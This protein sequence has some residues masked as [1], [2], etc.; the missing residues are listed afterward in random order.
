MPDGGNRIQ[1]VEIKGPEPILLVSAYMP[2]NGMQG[3]VDE[4]EDTLD[5]LSEITAKY[6]SHQIIIGGDFNEDIIEPNK[7]SKRLQLLQNFLSENKLSYR[8]VGKTYVNPNGIETSAIDYIFYDDKINDRLLSAI[9]LEAIPTNVSDH[10]PVC[11]TF[12]YR[13]RQFSKSTDQFKPS[14]KVKW[15]KLDKDRYQSVVTSKLVSLEHNVSSAAVLDVQ[16]QKIN[17]ILVQATDE[18]R[19]KPVKRHRKAR[20]NVWTAEIGLAVS[21]KKKA[22]WEWKQNNRPD[23]SDNVFVVNKKT[24]TKR[25]RKLC[26][27][28]SAKARGA[29]RQQI[30]DAKSN[31]TKLF[32]KLIDKQRGRSNICVNELN[33]GD[34]T[35]STSSEVL[36]GWREH[37]SKLATPNDTLRKDHAY[38]Q[39]VKTEMLEIFDICTHMANSPTNIETITVPEVKEAISSLNKNKAA[40]IYGIVAEHILYGGK[41]LLEFLTRII[42]QLFTFGKIPESLKLGVLTPVYKRKGLNTEAKNYRGITILPVI[43]KILEAVL[44]KKIQPIINANQS[45]LQR[46]FTKN[47]SPMN[48]SLI[49]EEAIRE[50]RDKRKPLYIAFLDAKSAFDVVNHDS[51]L[52][53]LYHI[54]IDG[55]T[56][57]LI[58]SL[59]DGGTTAVKWEGAVSD[60]FHIKQGVRQGGGV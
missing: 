60:I 19:P 52:R 11:C 12:Q 50:Q 6:S 39:L 29:D 17:D 33:V 40:D 56:W 53:K 2:C 47:S 5:Q 38:K 7:N 59:H 16:V 3:C 43:T 36:Q 28:E 57:L 51:L 9:R 42:N 48:C 4:F 23:Q 31:D 34:S 41:V 32:H 8:P 49:L 26:R 45:A 35:Y 54:G 13:F 24:T 55:A 44:R 10:I 25:L 46:G 58:Q 21:A 18:V 30:L 15:D 1:C 27:V 22:F 14:S 37:F 20:L